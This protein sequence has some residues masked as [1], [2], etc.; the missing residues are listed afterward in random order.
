MSS[1]TDGSSSIAIGGSPTAA[2]SSKQQVIS[3]SGPRDEPEAVTLA[4]ATNLSPVN[5][6]LPGGGVN[7]CSGNYDLYAE[8]VWGI[9]KSECTAEVD[10][11]KGVLLGLNA[12]TVRVNAIY[13]R[14][15]ADP[16]GQSP[17]AGVM[18]YA[19]ALP[20][21]GGNARAQRTRICG[22]AIAQNAS[23]GVVAIPA[24][25]KDVIVLGTTGASVSLETT[26]Y[27]ADPAA[28]A[29]ASS[30]SS[31][32]AIAIPNG[33]EWIKVKNLAADPVGIRAVFGL[34]L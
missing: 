20:G 22:S 29:I 5:G 25:A 14:T 27:G 3:W 18:I 30:G 12:N 32:S 8:V 4:I 6:F 2:G 16:P 13:A 19:H 17:P 21:M 9:G 15:A 28:A 31:G 7:Y 24:F 11:G 26:F 33:A 1:Y 10:I 23:T 34:Y